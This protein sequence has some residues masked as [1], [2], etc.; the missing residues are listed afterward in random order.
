MTIHLLQLWLPIVLAAV[1]AWFASAMIHMLLKYHKS[2]YAKLGNE[3]EVADALRN[4]SPRVGFYSLPHCVDMADMQDEAMQ[5]RFARGPVAFVTVFPNGMPKMGKLMAQQ[6]SFFLLGC[7]LVAYC[8]TLALPTG[9]PY[10][11]VFRFVGAVGFLTFGWAVVP[12][13]IWYGH[14]WSTTAKYLLD[15]LIYGLVVAGTFAW[16]WPAAM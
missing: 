9:A 11:A 4:G 8:A 16:L 15:A 2:D 6:I 14:P 12:F 3:D 5:Q 10:M 1:L 7:A 13:S